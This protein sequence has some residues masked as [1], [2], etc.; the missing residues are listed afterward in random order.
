MTL[1]GV[2]DAHLQRCG[3]QSDVGVAGPVARVVVRGDAVVVLRRRFDVGDDAVLV[4]LSAQ[5]V[6]RDQVSGASGRPGRGRPEQR[7]AGDGVARPLRVEEPF[8]LAGVRPPHL[9]GDVGAV[10]PLGRHLEP[11]FKPL[12]CR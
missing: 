8:Q 7:G 4:R 11:P 10:V 5:G 12:L 1:S 6:G 9:A 2:R 3:R